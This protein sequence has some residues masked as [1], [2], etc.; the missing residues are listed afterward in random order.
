M[1]PY[2]SNIWKLKLIRTFFWMH[3]FAAVMVPFFTDWG[4]LKLSQV[5][6]LNSWFMFWNFALE[7][8]TGTVAD[9]LG[10]K[11]SLALGCVVGAVGVLVYTSR[12]DFTVF[13]VAEFLS[14]I[15]YTLHSGADEALAYDSLKAAG[16]ES[17]SKSVLTQMESFKLAGIIIA[18]ILGGFIAARFG[19]SAPMRF[20]VFPCAAALLLCLSLKE[21]PFHTESGEKKAY[22]DVLHNGF[23][24]FA[25]NKALLTLTVEVSI[26]NAFAW[27]IIW[28][29]Q[30]LLEAAGIPLKLFGVV[31]A[32]AA[33]G[34]IGL[35]SGVDVLESWFGS[36]RRVLLAMSFLTALAFIA[37]GFVR[38]PVAVALAVV[39]AFT[40][41]LPRI[42]LFTAYMQRVIPSAQR[43]T[44]L[45]LTSMCRTL[46][47]VVINP[48][49]GLLAD[50]SPARTMAILG[51]AILLATVLSRIE[52]KHLAD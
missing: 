15:A 48:I 16:A 23:R 52:E 7:V 30:P 50:R 2:L 1:N 45:S 19:L 18:T 4:G 31:H 26:T 12:P 34:Q 6:F 14:A 11:V 3:F 25:G 28:L 17:R 32:V 49:I 39:A 38:A 10:R 40:F 37:L 41:S 35:L 47:I 46:A 13:L 33:A 24:A 22:L 21:A 27:A 42:P 29:F 20:Y 43:A 8:P 44:V 36:K 5:L 9:Y 51:S